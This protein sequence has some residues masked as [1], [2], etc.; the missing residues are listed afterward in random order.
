VG[1]I[2]MMKQNTEALTDVSK[3]VGLEVNI[4][5]TKCISMSQNNMK[6]ANRACEKV[7]KF[8][9]LGMAITNQN[10]ID[11]KIMNRLNLDF[12]K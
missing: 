8:K 1:I 10:L 6:V 12:L 3:K 4:E 7:A 5:K 11:E 9:Y 2:N